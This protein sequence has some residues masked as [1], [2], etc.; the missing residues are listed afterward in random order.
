MVAIVTAVVIND[1]RPP[2]EPL[3]SGKGVSYALLW[4]VAERCWSKEPADR[5]PMT[6]VIESLEGRP[7][8]LTAPQ[9]VATSVLSD[10]WSLFPL[11][12][13]FVRRAVLFTED[14]SRTSTLRQHPAGSIPRLCVGVLITSMGAVVLGILVATLCRISVVSEP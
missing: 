7:R 3:M 5:P 14:Y 13:R 11:I 2:K 8:T 9:S 10:N 12:G 1:E 6:R 4:T